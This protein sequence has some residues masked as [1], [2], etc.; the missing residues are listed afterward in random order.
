MEKSYQPITSDGKAVV[1]EYAN[2]VVFNW[3]EFLATLST[4]EPCPSMIKSFGYFGKPSATAVTPFDELVF[5]VFI[6][7]KSMPEEKG[8]EIMTD[9][10]IPLRLYTGLK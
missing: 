4:F 1:C 7:Q 6:V 5:A 2:Y 3:K 10:E 9:F 8:K